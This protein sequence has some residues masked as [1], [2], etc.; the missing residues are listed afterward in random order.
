MDRYDRIA[1]LYDWLDSALFAEKG[2]NPRQ[3]VMEML[4]AGRA[5]VLD[6][7]CGTLS[8]T[9]GIA[10]SR[11]ELEITGIDRSE[12]MLRAAERKAAAL[13]V[14]NVRLLCA[15]AADTRLPGGGFDCAVI[16]LVL[17]ECA[18]ELRGALLREAR[19]LLASGGS[20]IVLE[21]ERPK[22]L[23]R[24]VKFAPLYLGEVLGSRDFR[25]FYESDKSAFFTRHGF[26]V[27]R[28]EHC[29]YTVALRLTKTPDGP[30][31]LERQGLS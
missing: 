15:D 1:D 5:R 31:S 25:R 7:C 29:N 16:G 26:C 14:K 21:W 28:T 6:L 30:Q 27:E 11:P 20:L 4:P 12:G 24:R 8:N 10:R 13:G 19:R 18:P 23:R 17:H 22:T 9:L 2:R 3:A